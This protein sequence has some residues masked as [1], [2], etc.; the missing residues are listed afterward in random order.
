M[1]TT[2]ATRMVRA[3]RREPVDRI[4]VWMMRQAGRYMPEYQELRRKADFLTLCRDPALAAQATLDA[5]RYLDTDA[6]IIF[7]D[8]TLPAA[9]LGQ[10]LTFE[11]GPRLAPA[12]R[13]F[14][15]VKALKKVDVR[16]DLG[17]VLEAIRRT[18]AALPP[19]VSLIGFVGAPATLAAYMVEG[20]PDGNWLEFRK[21]VYGA[22]KVAEALI[23]RVAEVVAAHAAAQLDAGCDV[24]QLFDTS[25]GELPSSELK[26][27]AFAY[28]RQVIAGLKPKGAPVVYFARDIGGH[29]EAAADLGADVLALD[30]KVSISEAKARLGN[31][32]ALMGNLEPAVLLT[33]V[34]EIDRRVQQILQEAEG[35]HG[36]I[37]NL[38]HG[39]L[40]PTPPAHARQVVDSVK[41]HGVRTRG[42]A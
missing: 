17:V 39:V 35:L 27:L 42:V 16:R 23:E 1:T 29:L 40:P 22:P 28:A 41:R 13:T 25:A 31:S 33:S 10:A 6:A 20:K 34:E 7:S 3:C 38:G 2:K 24:V 19:E 26:G 21:L 12:I 36:F 37:F 4:P 5:A 30:W 14:D 8:I 18:R 32:V 9:A 11:P 15:D